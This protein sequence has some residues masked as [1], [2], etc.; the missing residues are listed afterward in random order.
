MAYQYWL[1]K[2]ESRPSFLAVKGSYHG[3][4]LGAVSVGSIGQFHSKFKPLLFKTHFAMEAGCIGCPFNKGGLRHRYRCGEKTAQVPKPG[5]FR[6]ETKCRWECLSD[7]EKILKKEKKVSAVILE[8]VVQAAG[9]MKVM[10]EGY[11]AGIARL[12]RRHNTLLII[13]EVATGFGRTGRMFASELENVRPDFLCVAKGLTGGYA[14]LAATLT[15]KRIY[16]AFWGPLERGRTFFHGHSY[17]GYPVGAAAARATLAFLDKSKLVEKTRRMA[18]ILKEELRR[19]ET[20]PS[21]RS[22]R[23]AGL[24]AGIELAA[25]KS[26]RPGAVVCQKLL[27]HGIWIRPLGNILVLMP[28]LVIS[29]KDLRRLVKTVGLVLREAGR[30]SR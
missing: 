30:D 28:P 6:A 11:V 17:T 4:T 12:A 9:G 27:K 26:Q 29:E 2:G 1:E 5:E 14:P 23:Q 3:D 16:K 13:D 8:P 7:A 25:E 20:L 19:L 24:M 10:P 15:T 21:V 18:H 22:I